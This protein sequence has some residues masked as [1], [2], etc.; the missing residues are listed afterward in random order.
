MSVWTISAQEGTN[1]AQ[2]A[3]GLAAAAGVSLLDRQ[4]L[5]VLA[6]EADPSLPEL[7]EVEARFGRFTMLSLSTAISVGSAE[8]CREVELRNKLPGLGRAVCCEATRSPC[9]IYLPAAFAALQDHPSAT[10][11]RVRAPFEYRVAIYQRDHLVDRRCAEKALKQSDH[12]RRAWVKSLYRVDI[13]D[14]NRFSLVVDAS[15]FSHD[16]LVDVLLATRGAPAKLAA[17]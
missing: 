15:C 8:A 3:A 13:D 11:V 16:R 7:D 14:P 6:H 4:A 17:A 9:V 12:R 5:A 1:G 10:H 2:I